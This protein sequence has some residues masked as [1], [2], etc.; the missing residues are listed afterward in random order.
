[1][2]GISWKKGNNCGFLYKLNNIF[3]SN[4]ITITEVIECATQKIFF[5]T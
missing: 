3:V 2:D 1:M 4:L 5:F